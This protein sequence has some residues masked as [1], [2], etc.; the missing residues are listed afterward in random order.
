MSTGEICDLAVKRGSVAS[1]VLVLQSTYSLGFEL[2]NSRQSYA[3]LLT[4][5]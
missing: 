2:S 4:L 3:I 5:I 1:T